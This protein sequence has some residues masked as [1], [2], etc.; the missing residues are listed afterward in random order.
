ML[1]TLVTSNATANTIMERD[2]TRS[3]KVTG[4]NVSGVLAGNDYTESYLDLTL[5]NTN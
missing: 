2:S 1:A 4:F 3:S 5:N